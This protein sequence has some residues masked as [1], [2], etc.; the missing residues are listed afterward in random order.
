MSHHFVLESEFESYKTSAASTYDAN[1]L[2]TQL[3]IGTSNLKIEINEEI[4]R[5]Y[6]SKDDISSYDYATNT[7]VT[8]L[9]NSLSNVAISGEYTDLNNAPDLSDFVSSTELESNYVSNA[10]LVTELSGYTASDELST[11]ALTGLYSDVV[12][13]PDISL[14]QTVAGMSDYV[15]QAEFTSEMSD[16]ARLSDIPTFDLSVYATNADV[17]DWLTDYALGSEISAVGYSGNFSDLTGIDSVVMEDELSVV[18]GD[19]VSESDLLDERANIDAAYYDSSELAVE[20]NALKTEIESDRSNEP[21][22]DKSVTV[23]ANKC[24]YNNFKFICIEVRIGRC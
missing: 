7:R 22:Y 8:T 24:G 1:N 15:L 18:L 21:Y 20:L 17:M 4:A 2:E 23:D 5:D 9:E 19:Y 16:V 12:G 13:A 11:V 14:Y 3:Q 10:D 6:V